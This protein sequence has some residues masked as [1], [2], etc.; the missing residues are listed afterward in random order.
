MKL[1]DIKNF[2]FTNQIGGG[3]LLSVVR[4]S[5]EVNTMTVSWGQ[6]GVL[7][8]KEVCTVYVRPERYTY[9]FCEESEIFTLSFLPHEKKD[10]LS[11]CGTKSGRDVDKFQ[12]CSLKHEI[13]NGTC[14][15]KD[16]EVTLVLKKLYAQDIRCD[17]FTDN[18]PLSNYK[19]GGFHRAYTCEIIDVLKN[20]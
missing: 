5:G 6:A 2:N 3:A 17:C 1:Q 20:N 19:T 10:V 15:L 18:S 16:S 8:G 4:P 7:W 13:K 11:F 14:I 12:S 9:G